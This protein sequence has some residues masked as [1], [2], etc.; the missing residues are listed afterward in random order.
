MLSVTALEPLWYSQKGAEPATLPCL[1]VALAL[2]SLCASFELYLL[3]RQRRQYA[4]VRVP[5]PI[6]SAVAS[7]A[8]AGSAG[9]RLPSPAELQASFTKS[10]R[11]GLDKS[12]L[13]ITEHV[14]NFLVSLAAL[15][16]GALPALYDAATVVVGRVSSDYANAEVPATIV[17]LALLALI[18]WAIGLPL[19]LYR[20]FVVEARHGFN[21]QTLAT[22]AYD[23]I[24]S[25]VIYLAVMA[26][27][28][29][30]LVSV[31]AWGGRFTFFVY[32]W[33]L[34][35]ALLI[36]TVLVYPVFIAPL[37]N[38]FTPLPAGSLRD[39]IVALARAEAFPVSAA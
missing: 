11:Y 10:Q 22:F 14:F 4:L 31:V 38:K 5:A 1:E 29:A 8:A 6:A 2:L 30:A 32:A 36:G 9:T 27:T 20:T 12:T 33:A 34:L 18:S 37:F 26:P 15:L 28:V 13:G 21:K 17:F 25:F 16:T 24:V 39:R 19:A 3:L 35:S 23:S 7:L